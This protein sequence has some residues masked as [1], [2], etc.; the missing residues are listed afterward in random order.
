M[1]PRRGE[2]RGERRAE[3]RAEPGARAGGL[4]GFD[5]EGAHADTPPDSD[6]ETE[7]DR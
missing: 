2:R 1:K 3:R 4:E 5:H 7:L 6:D